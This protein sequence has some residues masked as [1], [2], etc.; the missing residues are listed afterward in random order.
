MNAI[1]KNKAIVIM[2]VSGSGKSTIGKL[3]AE[4]IQI[5]FFDGDDFHSRE[6]VEKMASGK[7]LNDEDRKGWLL[8]LNALIKENENENGCIIACSSLK[9]S[10]RKILSREVS[11]SIKFVFL[12]GSYSEILFRLESRK[13]HF[14]PSSLL[15]SQFETLENP[16]NA[17]TLSIMQ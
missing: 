6:N 14:I 2:G 15:K 13:N 1:N 9:E 7:P 12:Q 8:Q 4:K 11:N 3:L 17:Y 5:P 10:Y 16:Q